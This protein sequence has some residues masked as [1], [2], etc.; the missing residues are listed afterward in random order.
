MKVSDKWRLFIPAKLA[1]ANR[2]HPKIPPNSP[3]S[4]EV[5]LAGIKSELIVLYPQRGPPL[6]RRVFILAATLEQL[7]K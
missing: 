7:T 3:L 1:Y 5:E 6:A 4:F 2:A